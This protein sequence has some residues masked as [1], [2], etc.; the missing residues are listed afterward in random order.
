MVCTC[1]RILIGTLAAA[2]F[3]AGQDARESLQLA[4]AIH[5]HSSFSNGHYQVADLA[6]M[7]QES[8]L[9]VLVLT[10]SFLTTA[11]YSL[12]LF[13]KIAVEGL[14]RQVRPGVRDH[15]IETYFEAV[16]QARRTAP[17]LIILAGVEVK[18][19]YYWQGTP[20]DGLTLHN[21]DRHLQAFGLTAEQLR[22]LPV[23]ENET[24]SN[25][26]KRPILFVPPALLLLLG[27][28]LL[29]KREASTRLRYYKLARVRRPWL[30]ACL[31]LGAGLLLLWGGYPFGRLADPYSGQDDIGPYQRLIDYVE[32]CGGV[33]YW[34]YP[35]AR[36]GDVLS[37]GARMVS[38][39]H[40]QSLLLSDGYHGF[41]GLYGDAITV[42]QPGR[43]WDQALSQYL[44]GARRRPPYVDTGIDFHY[45]KQGGRG[46]YSLQGGQTILLA[47]EKSES[48]VLEAMR[49][50]SLYATYQ[51]PPEKVRLAKFSLHSGDF[52]AGMGES[53][54]LAS[55]TSLQV[56]V[57]LDWL[58]RPT[59]DDTAF[60]IDLIRDGQVVQSLNSRLPIAWRIEETPPDGKH[61]Y[62][63]QASSGRSYQLL[64]NPIFVELGGHE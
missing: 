41:E 28:F 30:P 6:R 2:A 37:G 53:L 48:A 63:L 5:V 26:S 55:G 27:L 9:D 7:A 59:S 4:S 10:D 46:W 11:T 44:M 12:P 16:E 23:I 15:G 43:E 47:D 18:P 29:R 38:G 61:Y 52:Q 36:Y 33:V 32:Q 49:S 22:Q 8:G 50:G 51:E 40:P 21:F 56:K 14:N 39:P 64:S 24:W 34:S 45:L 17:G 19:Y 3:V 35:E 1:S 31:S 20:W 13:D 58:D 60:Q 57:S 54:R 25:T 42:T 62:R